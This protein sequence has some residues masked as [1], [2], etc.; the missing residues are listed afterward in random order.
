M[1]LTK[2]EE[3]TL[4][5]LQDKKNKYE[6]MKKETESRTEYYKNYAREHFGFGD[7]IVIED[8]TLVRLCN[9]HSLLE[10]LKEFLD[11]DNFRCECGKKLTKFPHGDKCRGNKH[12]NYYTLEDDINLDCWYMLGRNLWHMVKY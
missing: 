4:I 8:E 6:L 5:L 3:E 1:A 7:Q 9:S 10:H 2:D 12:Q 11:G